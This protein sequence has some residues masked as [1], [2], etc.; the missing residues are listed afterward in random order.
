[1]CVI[2][3]RGGRAPARR[4]ALERSTASPRSIYASGGV[5]PELDGANICLIWRI[6]E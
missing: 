2:L 5:R 3:S 6:C 4:R 1:M